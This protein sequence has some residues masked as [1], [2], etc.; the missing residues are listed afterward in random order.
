MPTGE[1]MSRATN[2]LVQVRLLLGFGLLNV[3]SSSF[4]L[5]SA[6]YVMVRTSG[7][8]TLAALATFPILLLTTRTF[9]AKLFAKNREN[10]EAIGKVSDRVLASLA[11]VRVIRSFALEDSET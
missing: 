3:L 9:S 8:L 4:A 10:Q 11:G 7:K 1:I 2:D 6:L 5:C